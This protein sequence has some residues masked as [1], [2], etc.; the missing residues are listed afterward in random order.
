MPRRHHLDKRAGGLIAAGCGDPDDLLDT[1]E[2]AAWLGVSV[3]TLEIWRCKR[4]G[5][6][7]VPLSRRCIRYKRATV[8]AWLVER[9]RAYMAEYCA[10]KSAAPLRNRDV[11]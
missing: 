10:R 9:E 1:K 2:L 8:L 3:S 6:P 7:A 5:P 11:T 4:Q